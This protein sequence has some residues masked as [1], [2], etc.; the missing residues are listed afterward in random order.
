MRMGCCV[1]IGC[2]F[3]DAHAHL[4]A[5]IVVPS[6]PNGVVRHSLACPRPYGLGLG[7]AE[8]VSVEAQRREPWDRRG[9]SRGV[10]GSQSPRI[11]TV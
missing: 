3:G 4:V 11:L 5:W 6:E 9:G 8:G 7:L 2:R 10:F 1:V